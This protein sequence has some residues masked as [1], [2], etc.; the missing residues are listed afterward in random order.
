M[1]PP[2]ILGAILIVVGILVLIFQGIP[3]TKKNTADIGPLK[4]EEKHQETYPV[5]P[6]LGVVSLGAG[7]FLV[8]LGSRK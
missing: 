6:I 2:V 5:S 1:K 7:I 8:V 4:L 3:F